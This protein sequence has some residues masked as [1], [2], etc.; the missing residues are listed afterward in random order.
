MEFQMKNRRPDA[1][2]RSLSFKN[3]TSQNNLCHVGVD[4]MEQPIVLHLQHLDQRRVSGHNFDDAFRFQDFVELL[5]QQ[6]QERVGRAKGSPPG[7]PCL[8]NSVAAF[9]DGNGQTEIVA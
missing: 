2:R 1:G 9:S 4:P 7:E 5:D 3:N 8:F 6:V